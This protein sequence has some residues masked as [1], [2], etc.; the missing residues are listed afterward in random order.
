LVDIDGGAAEK[1]G[2]AGPVGEEAPDVDVLGLG[3]HARQAM[4]EREGGNALA[5]RKELRASG[6]EHGSGRLLR[7]RRERRGQLVAGLDRVVS[8]VERHGLGKGLDGSRAAP[9]DWVVRVPED[10]KSR[11]LG[12]DLPEQLETLGV[13]VVR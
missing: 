11:E 12:Y 6:D 10:G 13:E 9:G 8:E 2:I 7:H 5:I 3:V 4:L 1:L